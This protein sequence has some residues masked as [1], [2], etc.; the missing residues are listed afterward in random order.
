M[1][2]TMNR[3]SFI[4]RG[5]VAGMLA[6]TIGALSAAGPARAS[7]DAAARELVM[8]AAERLVALILSEEPSTEKETK[9]RALM[10]ETAAMTAIGATALGTPW[11][12]MSKDQKIRYDAAFK[13]YL[14]RNYVSRFSDYTGEELAFVKSTENKR[15][16]YV[17]TTVRKPGAP[18]L[19]VVWR[20][21]KIKDTL[22]IVDIQAADIS[23]LATERSIMT[24]L[25]DRK[26]GDF[27]AL[28]L[29]LE[30]GET[31]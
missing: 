18:A 26:R 19:K 29:A 6:F 24:S 8:G 31:S 22:R 1:V 28:I 17:E 5:L 16:V 12:S 9:F 10:E 20:L 21:K 2:L 15:G 13:T 25:L 4:S 23:L 7:D 30:T 11:R 27:D 14:A 3:R